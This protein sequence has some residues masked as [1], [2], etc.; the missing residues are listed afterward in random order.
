M[1]GSRVGKI[2]PALSRI[3]VHFCRAVTKQSEKILLSSK[4]EPE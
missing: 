1:K 4:T 3:Q 2:L